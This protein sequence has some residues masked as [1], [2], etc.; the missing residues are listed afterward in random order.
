MSCSY[1]FTTDSSRAALTNYETATTIIMIMALMYAGWRTWNVWL[2]KQIIARHLSSIGKNTLVVAYRAIDS[3]LLCVTTATISLML[4]VPG[5]AIGVSNPYHAEQQHYMLHAGYIMALSSCALYVRV[6]AVIVAKF[7]PRTSLVIKWLDWLLL[8]Y[9]IGGAISII[10]RPYSNV[11]LTSDAYMIL[12]ILHISFIVILVLS[13]FIFAVTTLR[14]AL[15]RAHAIAFPP[16]A[17]HSHH[18]IGTVTPPRS[19]PDEWGYGQ[20]NDN[21]NDSHP[22][23]D[24][25]TQTDIPTAGAPI[26]LPS[27]PARSSSNGMS[28]PPDIIS[29]PSLKIAVGNGPA[30]D[31]TQQVGAMQI[32]GS[33]TATSTT[34]TATSGQIGDG[35]LNSGGMTT[36]TLTSGPMSSPADL[37]RVTSGRWTLP[38][39]AA[40]GAS[41]TPTA[42]SGTLLGSPIG[43]IGGVE[44]MMS[45]STPMIC[46][47]TGASSRRHGFGTNPS[48]SNGTIGIVTSAPPPLPVPLETAITKKK[49]HGPSVSAISIAI[50][51]SNAI[52]SV[53]RAIRGIQLLCLSAV[54]SLSVVQSVLHDSTLLSSLTNLVLAFYIPLVSNSLLVHIMGHVPSQAAIEPILAKLQLQR[55]TPI[56]PSTVP[57]LPTPPPRPATTQHHLL[58]N[59]NGRG[60]T[61]GT[62]SPVTAV[63][64]ITAPPTGAPGH[65]TRGRW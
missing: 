4:L 9:I 65:I 34:V 6:F 19:K 21:D 31:N 57:A 32:L 56:E 42:T 62:N 15:K 7:S 49:F 12:I 29:M 23:G 45:P 8:V 10:I 24:R 11:Q 16:P 25:A 53:L 46:S 13:S 47:A 27:P 43:T 39:P 60:G 36:R 44:L 26:P 54:V 61:N 58:G 18:M 22:F 3:Q 51:Q 40:V 14:S 55:H 20:N 48:N 59:G 30:N 37:T 33:P 63:R 5:V 52:R 28:L 50:E 35:I 17:M 41:S 1:D 64:G 38:P 2:H